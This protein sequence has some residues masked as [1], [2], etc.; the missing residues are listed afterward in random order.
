MYGEED[1]IFYDHDVRSELEEAG[2]DQ[3]LINFVDPGNWLCHKNYVFDFMGRIVRTF[4]YHIEN[5]CILTNEPFDNGVAFVTD[6]PCKDYNEMKFALMDFYGKILTD[7]FD[8]V[9]EGWI[10]STFIAV[11]RN[12][13]WGYIDKFGRQITDFCFDWRGWDY[14]WISYSSNYE[15]VRVDSKREGID[16]ELG[17]FTFTGILALEPIY[18]EIEIKTK[19]KYFENNKQ[20]T[21]ALMDDV[22]FATDFDDN[23]FRWTHHHGL[24]RI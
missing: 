16:M 9:D 22:I 11:E 10:D 3:A 15:I 2:F 5:C 17:L 6:D 12:L 8:S 1:D 19:F 20:R 4:D 23:K 18:K 7:F 13:K 14:E 24:E 21:S